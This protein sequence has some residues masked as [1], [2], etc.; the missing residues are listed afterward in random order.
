MNIEERNREKINIEERNRD[1]IKKN[2]ILTEVE[3]FL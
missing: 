1:T 3:F 2:I